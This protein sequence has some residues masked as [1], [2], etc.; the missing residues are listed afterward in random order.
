MD[1]FSSP[2]IWLQPQGGCLRPPTGHHPTVRAAKGPPTG[3][4]RATQGS[5]RDRQLDTVWPSWPTCGCQLA[6]RA[7]SVNRPLSAP[8]H[9]STRKLPPIHRPSSRS[10]EDR[11]IMDEPLGYSGDQCGV[12]KAAQ[13]GTPGRW[14]FSLSFSGCSPAGIASSRPGPPRGAWFRLISSWASSPPVCRSSFH[15]AS[16][17]SPP[18]PRRHDDNRQSGEDQKNPILLGHTD[19]SDQPAGL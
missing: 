10:D 7:K 6:G 11:G 17:C 14:S 16:S 3:N 2:P 9:D 19:A 18:Q 8:G 1:G 4:L 13:A 5:P 12:L 15:A